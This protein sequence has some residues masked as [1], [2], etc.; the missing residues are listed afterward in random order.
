MPEFPTSGPV[1]VDV[2]LAGGNV[3]LYAEPRETAQV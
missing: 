2:R 3:E 1:T